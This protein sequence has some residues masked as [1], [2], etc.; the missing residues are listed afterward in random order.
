MVMAVFY[1][2]LHQPFRLHPERDKFLWDDMNRDV[3]LK[4]AEKCYLPATRMFTE[5]VT[6][7]PDFKITFSM[8]GTFLEQ[9]ELYRPEVIKALQEL[10]D[11]GRER[12]QVE[13][14]DETYYHSLA[15]LFAD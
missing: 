13:F 10:A 15:S 11:A 14:L 12:G 1:F 2:Q 4:V 8:S 6:N 7:H 9:A 5:L 3:F